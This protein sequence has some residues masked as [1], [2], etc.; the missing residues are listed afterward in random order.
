M[1]AN[2]VRSYKISPLRRSVLWWVLGPFILMALLFITFAPANQ[3]GVG[4]ALLLV[5]SPFLA[6]GHWYMGRVRLELSAQGVTQRHGSL[7]LTAPWTL[8]ERLRVDAG[9]EGFV[10]REPLE[11]KAADRLARYSG[12]WIGGVPHYDPEQQQ[13]MAER[14]FIPIDPFAYLLRDGRLLADLDEFAPAIASETRP[15]VEAQARL[16]RHPKPPPTAAEQ[17]RMFYLFFTIAIM[18]G[19]GVWMAIAPDSLVS[20]IADKTIQI[21]LGISLLVWSVLS[22]WSCRNSWRAGGRVLAVLFLLMAFVQG[23][24]GI[25]LTMDLFTGGRRVTPTPPPASSSP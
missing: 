15:L 4:I 1:S 11:G 10:T 25:L 8:I 13:L 17:M 20:R 5:M 22:V 18:L 14:R 3:K 7:I 23:C 9:R 2:A 12:I 6:W 16:K 24:F 19:L 21:A